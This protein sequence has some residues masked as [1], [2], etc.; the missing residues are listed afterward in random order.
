MQKYL[1]RKHL[2]WLIIAAWVYTFTFIFNNY[3]SKYA[4]YE[5]VTKSFQKSVTERERGFNEWVGD[6]AE[7]NQLVDSNESEA[8]LIKLK[9]LPFHVFL[10]TASDTTEVP[11]FWSTNAV[12][13]DP[14]HVSFYPSG[15]FVKYGNGQYELLKRN[16]RV[17]NRSYI[18]VG[19]LQLHEE[20]FIENGSLRKEY[21]GFRGLGG[22]MELSAS[23]TEY[24]IKGENGKP[25]VYFSPQVK[26]P[27]Y[28][29]NWASF[30]VECFASIFLVIFISKL[31]QDI[32]QKK[33]LTGL[34]FFAGLLL[35]LRWAVGKYGIPIALNHFPLFTDDSVLK[36]NNAEE[37]R[38]FI[39]N[40]IFGL[41]AGTFT[42]RNT[43]II[44]NYLSK[45]IRSVKWVLIGLLC[46]VVTG[47]HFF[48]AYMIRDLYLNSSVAFDLT[49][50]FSFNYTTILSFLIIFLL[51][52][53]HYMVLRF[54]VLVF[55]RLS[56]TRNWVIITL[57]SLA[58]LI[59]LSL[60]PDRSLV[61]PLLTSLIWLLLFFTAGFTRL[62]KPAPTS[63]G[64]V[65]AWLF[66][67]AMSLSLFLGML[68][69]NRLQARTKSLSKSLMLQKDETS[70]VLVKIAAANVKKTDWST[71]IARCSDERV[72]RA[73]KDS[74]IALY[75]GGYL[76]RYKTYIYLFSRD[77]ENLQNNTDISYESLNTLF[78]T[79]GT[80]TD[81][82]NLAF[83][84][85][86]FDQFG[87]IIKQEIRDKVNGSL[88]GY[89]FVMVRSLRSSN[90]AFAP[91]LFR[92]LQNFAI[93]LPQDFSYAWYKKG[94]LVEQYRNYPFQ[95]TLPSAMDGNLSMWENV[96]PEAYELWMS[97]GGDT[98]LALAAQRN[99]FISF[100]SMLA[101]LFGS[102]LIFYFLL[103]MGALV[104][105]GK[106]F[107][108]QAFEKIN[109]NLQTKIRLTV[110]AILMI[111]FIIV[112][113]VTIS[114]FIG[115]FKSDNTEKL[116]KTVQTISAELTRNMP[117]NYDT[118]SKATQVQVL[119]NVLYTITKGKDIDVNCFDTTGIIIAS[120]QKILFEKGV[121]SPM[122]D[123]LVW[124]NLTNGDV[125][126]Y[127]SEESIGSLSYSSIYQPLLNK[128]NRLFLYLQVPFF[129]SENELNQ[130]ISNF[131]VILI[132]IIAFVFLLSGSLAYWISGNITKSFNLIAEKMNDLRLSE[133]NERIEWA[134]KD[135]IGNL[136]FQYNKMVDQLEDSAKKMARNEREL[137]W[138]E[139]A[140]QV[141]H[142]IKNPLTPMKL[143]L[144][145]LQKAIQENNS[146]VTQITERVASN[147]VGQIDHLSKIA[148]EFS[149]FA[150]LG[151][152]KPEFFNL[153]MTMQNIIQM[154]EMQ[155]NLSVRW[156]SLSQPLNIFADKTQINRLLTNLFQN[157]SEAGA[158]RKITQI[159]IG[160]RLIPGAVVVSFA[161]DG[162]GIPDAVKN[163]IFMPNFTTKSAG[164][165][166]GLSICKAI[167][168]NAG[169]SIWFET[170]TGVGTTFYVRLPLAK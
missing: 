1:V 80:P 123:P 49:N 40:A 151:N 68:S 86:S 62:I 85:E 148:T 44:L 88:G 56:T 163:N 98:V 145:F 54:A 159:V 91:E 12:L 146:D 83:F 140:K 38:R 104:F 96:T 36:V 42:T 92:Q 136:V 41:W 90:Q 52:V 167:V 30:L 71:I 60:I 45:K 76:D 149:Q 19:L 93:N 9:S 81:N 95:T 50:F 6:S 64:I 27:I 67:Y 112:A 47:G 32:I 69:D 34:V 17:R 22:K 72:C 106:L 89:V 161:D 121:I 77:K 154:Y 143:S 141:A 61:F 94:T 20:F 8:L 74:I 84:G 14:Y 125:H 87:Y 11:V 132:N 165:G 160:E 131:L 70:E 43:A 103:A 115:Q 130:E 107:S 4:S 2:V 33:L 114:F 134:P 24:P 152:Y 128:N 100:I 15:S 120:T 153:Q 170:E 97:A 75:F 133:H 119:Q 166:L 168:E 102:F 3:W 63:S 139:M 113:V 58:G 147:L 25:I 108:S 117:A 169:G 26:E 116:A 109:L 105:K 127:I 57:L 18:L 157:A 13:P 144:Q 155:E 10:F 82:L 150:N 156:H 55:L 142:E 111:S 23:V 65:V 79:Q 66:I 5:S 29:F 37:L 118:L 48:L 122:A 7:I 137:A 162:E 158:N 99:V 138:R 164:T 126:R 35:L 31:S 39:L 28:I 135:E 124:W 73:K 101:Y 129:A 59:I 53:N 51:C 78:T 110:I 21:P 46:L 16:V